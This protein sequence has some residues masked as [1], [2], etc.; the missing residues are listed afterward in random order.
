MMHSLKTSFRVCF[1]A[2]LLVVLAWPA[3]AEVLSIRTDKTDFPA[4]F[5][6]DNTWQGMDIE[7]IEQIFDRTK[8]RIKYIEAPFPRS[9]LQA[10][11]GEI[12]LIPNLVKNTKRSEFMHW[13]G[14]TRITCIG[15]VVHQNDADLHIN[16]TQALIKLAKEREQKIGYLSGA[17]YSPFLD[18]E[19]EDN[20]ALNEVLH[21]LPDNDQHRQMLQLGRL[22]GYFYDAFEMQRRL[23]DKHFSSLY[24]N[25]AL[26]AY[27]IEES[28]TGAF[29]G[30]SKKLSHPITQSLLEA[31][32]NM[33][34][35][36]SF[37]LI[38]QKWVGRSPNF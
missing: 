7:I 27:R 3:F 9:I 18:K 5:F 31:F 12:H 8:H 15:L 36:G 13:L 35:D 11:K 29:I 14:P 10:E 16:S 32:E 24:E 17:S 20:T 6:Q 33:K 25:L 1:L 21:F 37:D 26:N 2:S 19:L 28:C 4:V 38:H 30:I 34:Q 22:L 23:T